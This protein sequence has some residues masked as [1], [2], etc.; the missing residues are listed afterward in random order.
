MCGLYCGACPR[1][2]KEK[3]YGCRGNDKATWCKLRTCCMGKNIA[4]CADC[5]EFSDVMACEKYNNFMA[6][7]FGFVFNSNRSA[8]IRRIKAVGYD[9]FAEEMTSKKQMSI[10][11]K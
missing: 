11:R 2:L 10:K 8:C 6:R 9:K 7:I 4:S 3:C 5:S 1:F